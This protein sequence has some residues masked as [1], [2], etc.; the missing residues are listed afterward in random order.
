MVP[1]TTGFTLTIPAGAIQLTGVTTQN[2]A[3]ISFT[4][5]LE[6]GKRYTIRVLLV[7]TSYAKFAASNIYWDGQKLT[8]EPYSATPDNGPGSGRNYQGVYFKHG[9]LVGISSMGGNPSS[10]VGSVQLYIPV[11][12]SG[13]SPSWDDTKTIATSSYGSYTAIPREDSSSPIADEDFNWLAHDDQ[14]TS[15][16]WN[17]CKGDICRYISENGYGPSDGKRYRL[18]LMDEFALS[19]DHSVKTWTGNTNGW[20][21][22]NG[23]NGAS[24]AWSTDNT[25]TTAEGTRT[26]IGSGGS[27]GPTNNF[28]PASGYRGGSN[29]ALSQT[30][31]SGTYWCGSVDS[32]NYPTYGG[33]MY[34]STTTMDPYRGND[35]RGG[36][37]VRCVLQ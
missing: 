26:T 14:N 32:N 7:K 35:R 8:F 28:F 22:V 30:G 2:A 17:N 13:N 1:Q 9:S 3:S 25:G 15:A 37:S 24:S 31:Q 23:L 10:T 18:P 16:M 29:G 12:N 20:T 5:A 33:N 11:Y 36:W 27:Y 4:N 19:E 34:I 21:K 6:A